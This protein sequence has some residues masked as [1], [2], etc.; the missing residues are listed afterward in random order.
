M[1][2][3]RTARLVL[4]WAATETIN[5][6]GLYHE[7]D[8]NITSRFRLE[9][10]S[11]IVSRT[12]VSLVVWVG[13]TKMNSHAEGDQPMLGEIRREIHTDPDLGFRDRRGGWSCF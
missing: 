13:M 9:E 4:E 7:G 1:L 6:Y 11:V 2:R 12:I 8:S 5:V 3:G 10:P